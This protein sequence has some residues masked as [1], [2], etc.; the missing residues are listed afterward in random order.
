MKLN[1]IIPVGITATTFMT[2]YSYILSEMKEEHFKEPEILGKL[3]QNLMPAI[4]KEFAKAAGWEIHYL[5]GLLF[6]AIYI[7]L[8]QVKKIKPTLQNGLLFGGVS[9]LIAVTVWKA[10]LKLHP[11]PPH[12]K[13]KRYYLQLIPAHIVFGIAAVASYVHLNKQCKQA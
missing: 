13:Y 4:R 3:L 7:Y 10:V 8:W 2:L 9:G 12:L 11:D 1:K 5:V 6:A